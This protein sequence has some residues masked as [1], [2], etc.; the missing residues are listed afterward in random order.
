M[1]IRSK[2]LNMWMNEMDALG[3]QI[4]D[5]GDACHQHPLGV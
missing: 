4:L 5:T 1:H 2:E 3:K